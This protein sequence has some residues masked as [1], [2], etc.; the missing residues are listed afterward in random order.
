MRRIMHATKYRLRQDE[1]VFVKINKKTPPK[2]IYLYLL[3]IFIYACL[4]AVILKNIHQEVMLGLQVM[5]VFSFLV[6]CI[7]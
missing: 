6:D 1:T 7:L 5:L 3:F 4:Y 2:Y